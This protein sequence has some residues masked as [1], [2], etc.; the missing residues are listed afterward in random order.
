M[1]KRI[2]F[3]SLGCPKTLVDSERMLGILAENG[4]I[5][6]EDIKDS[7]AVIINTCGFIADSREESLDTIRQAVE[8][9]KEGKIEKVF[10]A[11]CLVD[12]YK[13]KIV[14]KVQGVD[15]FLSSSKRDSIVDFLRK[16][17]NNG[18]LKNSYHY[19][20]SQPCLDD[21]SR[22]RLTPKHY[23]YVKISEGCSNPCSFCSI[24][25][26][27]GPIVSKPQSLIIEEIKELIADGAKEI[28]LVAQDT[29]LYGFDIYRR[30][31]FADLLRNIVLI[32]GLKWLRI[33]YAHP[34]HLTKEVIDIIAESNNVVKYID[35][36]IQHI[37]DKVLS[38]MNRKVG[39][40]YIYELIDYI[41]SKSIAIRTSIIVGFPG[42][43][44]EDFNQLV[45]FLEKVKFDRLGV[46]M[47]SREPHTPSFSYPYQVSD[48]EKARRFEIVMKLQEKIAYEK[49]KSF[50]GKSIECI[51]D[52]KL[53]DQQFQFQG[54]SYMDAPEVD[55][56]VHF[57]NNTIKVGEIYKSVRI[58]DVLGY[59]LV[60]VVEEELQ[61]KV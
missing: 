9:K 53:S 34:A 33:L 54:R 32:D 50:I 61:Q 2:S 59:D 44:E 4:Y 40:K 7:Q 11:G 14:N 56:F 10:V 26:I 49:N 55:G 15:G 17:W 39:Q 23:A 3:I 57:K 5:I 29:T 6:C 12:F 8:L 52:K 16:H 35:I 18:T 38:L 41:K 20:R 1:K 37:S 60:G 25:R 42:E 58:I 47:Y 21:R 51:V 22:L 28:I 45:A 19:S 31:A 43:E 24:P 27:K 46:F 30:G 36:P 13:E 48:Q